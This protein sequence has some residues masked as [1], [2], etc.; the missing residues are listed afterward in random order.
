[1]NVLNAVQLALSKLRDGRGAFDTM[2]LKQAN[3]ELTEMF[4]DVST[5]VIGADAEKA[6]C[7]SNVA[8]CQHI[9]NRCSQALSDSEVEHGNMKARQQECNATVRIAKEKLAAAEIEV[10][11]S[12]AGL[13]AARNTLSIFLDGASS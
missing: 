9:L 3:S 13:E 7:Q 6:E 8:A 5:V 4:D 1:M 2:V 12:S 10:T 11:Q